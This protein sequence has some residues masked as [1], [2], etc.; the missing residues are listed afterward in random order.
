[1]RGEKSVLGD[2][3]AKKE[4]IAKTPKKETI[5]NEYTPQFYLGYLTNL[6]LINNR[7]YDLRNKPD[8]LTTYANQN[9]SLYGGKELS[10]R[11]AGNLVCKSNNK[12]EP[13]C[14][15]YLALNEMNDDEI[16]GWGAAPNGY[17]KDNPVIVD[18]AGFSVSKE[19]N[20]Y[21]D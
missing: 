16:K 17:Y 6:R 11:A 20:S 4:E 5:D 3:K 12:G 8:G 21:Y 13:I 9:L 18:Y 15:E 7:I 10:G 19:D 1:M 2:L 14:S